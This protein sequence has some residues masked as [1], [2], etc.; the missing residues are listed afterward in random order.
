MDQA[1]SND[2]SIY[3]KGKLLTLNSVAKNISDNDYECATEMI[4]IINSTMNATRL[5]DL[6]EYVITLKHKCDLLREYLGDDCFIYKEAL[7]VIFHKLD[8]YSNLLKH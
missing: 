7:E 6:I 4:S 3:V 8:K 2:K 1:E 5:K